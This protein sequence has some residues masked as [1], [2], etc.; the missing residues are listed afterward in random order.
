MSGQ[1]NW[2]AENKL[3]EYLMKGKQTLERIS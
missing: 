1:K 3:G 2:L